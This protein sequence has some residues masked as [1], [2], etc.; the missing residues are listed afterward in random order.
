MNRALF[1]YVLLINQVVTVSKMRMTSHRK[2]WRTAQ[3]LPK[4]RRTCIVMWAGG[5]NFS[6]LE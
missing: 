4:T 6:L 1:K 5:I 3:I 2:A